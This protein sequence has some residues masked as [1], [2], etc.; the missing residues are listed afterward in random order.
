MLPPPGETPE[1]Q[2]VREYN[3]THPSAASQLNPYL[4]PEQRANIEAMSGGKP[5]EPPAPVKPPSC[6]ARGCTKPGVLDVPGWMASHS[7]EASKGNLVVC[8]NHRDEFLQ[9]VRNLDLIRK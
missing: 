8:T 9:A 1:D 4:T 5:P 7:I 2:L 3:E 6:S